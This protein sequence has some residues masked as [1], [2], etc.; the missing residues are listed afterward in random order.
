MIRKLQS[1]EVPITVDGGRLFFEEGK[2]P[3][4]F[5]PEIFVGNWKRYIAENRGTIYASFGADGKVHGAL[6]AVFYEDPFNGDK[7]ATEQF[8]Y[9][10]P[11][12]RNSREGLVLLNTFL[13]DAKNRGC[14]RAMMIHLEALQPEIL[15]AL[16]GRK[17]FEHVE[18]SYVKIL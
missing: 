9:T 3:G 7:V 4:G 13:A 17:G 16:Y 12:Y 1:N 6:G 14:K 18:S 11:Q 8:W 2:M 15:K 5:A 10:I